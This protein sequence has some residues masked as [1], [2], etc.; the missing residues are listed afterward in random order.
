MHVLMVHQ[1]FVAINEPGGTRHH[2]MA[3]HLVAQ[4]HRVTV[5]AGQVS[6]LTG[7]R[8]PN[9]GWLSHEIDETGVEILRCYTAPGW[10]RSFMRR[11]LSFFSFM[12]SSLIA[13]LG[14]ADVDVVWGTSP[15]IFQAA[16]AWAL[17]RVKRARCLLEVRDLWPEFAIAVG[18]LRNP[19]LIKLSRWLEAFLYRHADQIVANSPGYLEHIR[20]RGGARVEVVTN[21]VDASMFYPEGDGRGFKKR[22]GI[23]SG[24][25]VLYAGAHGLSNDLGTLLEA[26][27]ELKECRDCLI[28]L[29][30][31][32]KEKINLKARAVAMDLKNVRFLPPI[33]KAEMPEALAA[34]SACYASLLPLDVYKTTYPNKV[35]DY[36][37]AGRPIVLAIDGVIRDV[38]EG[39]GAGI[40]VPPGNSRA[41]ARA[42]MQL[43]DNPQA[44]H[45]MGLAGRQAAEAYFSRQAAAAKMAGIL[46]GLLG[47]EAA[48]H[49]DGEQVTGA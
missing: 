7:E 15:P 36:M 48:R 44:A 47:E 39:S 25:I 20:G 35:F 8:L 23:A 16:T 38:V 3:Q 26:A 43:H 28:V 41:V 14:V 12:G 10:H 45:T 49:L 31:D 1:A 40:F 11:M 32:G 18:V 22:H 29:V 37:A 33:A 34:A 46:A 27:S 6:Y 24:F 13:G 30:G 5:L 2:E 17:A 19:L 42:I 4:G 9:Q 21:G